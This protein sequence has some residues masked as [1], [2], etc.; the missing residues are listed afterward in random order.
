MITDDQVE[1]PEAASA[2]AAADVGGGG[3]TK[4]L[5]DLTS[6]SIVAIVVV[7]IGV[8]SVELGRDPTRL[9]DM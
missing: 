9:T 7:I 6:T 5:F 1:N 8:A 4:Y 3:V 2:T